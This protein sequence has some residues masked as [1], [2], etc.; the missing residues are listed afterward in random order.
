MGKFSLLFPPLLSG[1]CLRR[2]VGFQPASRLSASV[3]SFRQRPVRS[4]V[5]AG[6]PH[7]SWPEH[8]GG[9]C[10]ADCLKGRWRYLPKA[11]LDPSAVSIARSHAGVDCLQWQFGDKN[12]AFRGK[13]ER[14]SIVHPPV[15]SRQWVVYSCVLKFPNDACCSSTDIGSSSCTVVQLGDRGA[16]RRQRKAHRHKSAWSMKKK[17]IRDPERRH[18][19]RRLWVVGLACEQTGLSGSR[20]LGTDAGA[21]S[22][23]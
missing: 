2:A 10:L 7:V 13:V 11:P 8:P 20:R 22:G 21:S 15:H 17:T 12:G 4:P 16:V 1:E 5:G 14:G 18:A 9:S 6:S 19:V 23:R 3:P